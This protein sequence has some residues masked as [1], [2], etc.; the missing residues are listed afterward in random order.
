[1]SAPILFNLEANVASSCID[2]APIK[3]PSSYINS[4]SIT[5]PGYFA[6]VKLY[7]DKLFLYSSIIPALL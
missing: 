4:L 3:L 6:F 7:K 2:K 1:M 5:N